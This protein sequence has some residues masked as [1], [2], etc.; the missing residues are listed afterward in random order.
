MTND[1]PSRV[2]KSSGRAGA[3]GVV[4]EAEPRHDIGGSTDS[5]VRRLDAWILHSDPGDGGGA[6]PVGAR[7]RSTTRALRQMTMG[8]VAAPRCSAST[9]VHGPWPGD[10]ALG[11]QT[12]IERVGT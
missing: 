10:A 11:S 4:P 9:E 6:W 12:T 3:V 8:A 2:A 5:N 7:V 1:V